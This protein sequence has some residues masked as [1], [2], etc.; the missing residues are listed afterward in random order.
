MG[1]SLGV[2]MGIDIPF[3]TAP[4]VASRRLPGP[5]FVFS[6]SHCLLPPPA[7]PQGLSTVPEL[8]AMVSEWEAECNLE[9][10]EIWGFYPSE[11]CQRC[12]CCSRCLPPGG[13]NGRH[14][15]NVDNVH[16]VVNVL[17]VICVASWREAKTGGNVDNGYNVENGKKM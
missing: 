1:V 12:L 17:C 2:G 4:P 11:R 10:W 16:N 3:P 13:K 7:P 15:D 5:E 14:V 8:L 6:A 9:F